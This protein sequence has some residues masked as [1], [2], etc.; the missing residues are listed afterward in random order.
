MP[1]LL[2]FSGPSNLAVNNNI[3]IFSASNFPLSSIQI[4]NKELSAS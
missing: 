4:S 3:L 1:I 2:S